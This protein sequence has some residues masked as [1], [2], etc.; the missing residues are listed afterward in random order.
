MAN[1]KS[2][3]ALPLIAL[4]LLV[5]ACGPA[6]NPTTQPGSN[7]PIPVDGPEI[8]PVEYDSNWTPGENAIIGA[9]QP[10]RKLP[11]GEESILNKMRRSQNRAGLPSKGQ[12]NVLVVPIAFKGDAEIQ[13]SLSSFDIN[14]TI[15]FINIL[16]P[17]VLS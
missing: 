6:S 14:F 13:A 1:K 17:S 8:V 11:K 4:S 7:G 15:L 2:L 10:V 16:L 5:A 12:S 9:K 3:L